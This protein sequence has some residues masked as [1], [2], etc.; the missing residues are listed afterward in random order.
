MVKNTE[1]Q[2]FV[3]FPGHDSF[4]TVMQTLT[5]GDPDKSQGMFHFQ[6]GSRGPNGEMGPT[7]TADLD[8]REEFFLHA[9]QDLFDFIVD[10]Q[11]TH[12]G[13]PTKAML[14]SLQNWDPKFNLQRAT[15]EERLSWRRAFTIN[16]LYDLINVFSS[17]V[18][19]R[20]TLKKQNIDLETVDW[21]KNGPWHVHRRLYG[22]NEFAGDITH[23]VMQKPMH[24]TN[25]QSKILPHH[26]FQLQCIVDSLTVSRGW[27]ISTMMGHVLAPP[28]PRFRP[29]RDV[30][31]FM[32]RE[33][34]RSLPR[35]LCQSVDLLNMV[36]DK[37]A[38]IHGDPN[39]NASCK[40]M[41]S[42]IQLDMI[43]WLGESKYMHGL[44]TIP[45]SRFSNT[46]SNDLWEYSPF[47]CGAGLSEAL[48]QMCSMGLHIWDTVPEV[49]CIIHLHNMVLQKGLLKRAVGLWAT[50]EH[51]FQDAFFRDG[52]LP[53][54]NFVAAFED[55]IPKPTS[56]RTMLQSRAQRQGTAKTA[57]EVADF[58]D[59]SL[60]R[61]FKS[62]SL[63]RVLHKAE[64]DLDRIPD[65]D[66][67]FPTMLG[68]IRI[69]ETKKTRD[70]I[71]GKMKLAEND[72]I[73]R[74]KI[75]GA[76]DAELIQQSSKLLSMMKDKPNDETMK[77]LIKSMTPE[78][79]QS[80]TLPSSTAGNGI[81]LPLYMSALKQDLIGDISSELRPLSSPNYLLILA[82]AHMRFMTMEDQ[83]RACRNPTWREAYEGHPALTKNK[84][85]SFTL[86]ALADRDPECLRIIA[87]VFEK[88]R[89]GFMDCIYWDDLLDP[90]EVVETYVGGGGS[91]PPNN[92]DACVVM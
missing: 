28:A 35:G 43:N 2:I 12:S 40:E 60:N 46:D 64:W 70:P 1:S 50:L 39:K 18:V 76:T 52:K 25:V 75:R 66:I 86:L 29:R 23:L 49:M 89:S 36:F 54:S 14:K 61:F 74:A 20:R 44:D 22:L 68:F 53:T 59:P 24:G 15:K 62:G 9:Y 67:P 82:L 87:D 8:V 31:L 34:K 17:I 72:L 30:D 85:A 7:R 3:D 73:R 79:Y 69:A 13:K 19:Q 91:A 5:R 38:M 47:L 63:L 16:W 10:F 92:P 26:V 90:K 33:A 84:R 32:D 4:N 80:G 51:F 48:D 41:L 45:G 42:A 83:L 6:I 55:L 57:T 58:V 78:G 21:S 77:K 56:H 37:D 88:N 65:E 27:T 81:D 71:T 11:K